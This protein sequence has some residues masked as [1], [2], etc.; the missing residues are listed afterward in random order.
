MHTAVTSRRSPMSR[1]APMV[2]R[3]DVG[4]VNLENGEIVY[5]R[6]T[7]RFA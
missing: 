4:D 1:S 5:E 7:L 3:C 2:L 6:P